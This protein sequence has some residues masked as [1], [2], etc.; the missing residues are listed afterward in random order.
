MGDSTGITGGTAARS[1]A[2]SLFEQ[3]TTALRAAGLDLIGTQ[4]AVSFQNLRSDNVEE[5][6]RDGLQALTEAT[7]ADAVFI[8]LLDQS[9][10]T[11]LVFY[12]VLSSFSSCYPLFL[13]YLYLSFFPFFY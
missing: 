3:T 10:R 4:I 6:V 7:G 8:A 9:G 5:R 13:Y 11:F 1:S 12:A 2:T